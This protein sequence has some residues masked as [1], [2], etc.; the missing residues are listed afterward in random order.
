[1]LLSFRVNSWIV[2]FPTVLGPGSAGPFPI[3]LMQL[4]FWFPQRELAPS[5]THLRVLQTHLRAS[6][7]D[8]RVSQIDLRTLQTYLQVSQ[9][10]L[11][12]LQ[13]DLRKVQV[14]L[15][16]AQI[17]PAGTA[18]GTP[19]FTITSPGFAKCPPALTNQLQVFTMNTSAAK[20][21]AS[22]LSS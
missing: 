12:T 17:P 22:V 5:Q 7:T 19:S 4:R 1:M 20:R 10:Q 14:E 6:Q 8:L 18:D 13:S 9:T 16:F 15:R 21:D 2:F 11:R 3:V